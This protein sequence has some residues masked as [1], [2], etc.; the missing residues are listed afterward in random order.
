MTKPIHILIVEDNPSDAELLVRELH[1]TN[2]DFEWDLVDTEAAFL[3]K[4]EEGIDLI[5][6]DY[7]LPQ[8]GGMRA[9]ELLKRRPDLDIPFI[10]VSGTIGEDTAV[11]A[12]Q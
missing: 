9:L 12:M 1:R 4:L 8:F 7:E 5:L 2:L 11:H 10:L 6:S 3:P